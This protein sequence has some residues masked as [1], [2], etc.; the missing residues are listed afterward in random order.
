MRS[1]FAYYRIQ[2]GSIFLPALWTGKKHRT[3]CPIG[4]IHP[5]E[6]GTYDFSSKQ[7]YRQIIGPVFSPFWIVYKKYFTPDSKIFISCSP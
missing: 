6:N 2:N 3:A 1:A 4:Y 7:A 5:M